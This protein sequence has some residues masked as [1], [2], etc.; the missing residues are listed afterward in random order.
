MTQIKVSI[1][2][3]IFNCEKYISKALE[4][5]LKQTEKNIEII[6]VNDGSTDKTM[7]ILSRFKD[8]RIKFI[9]KP[10]SGVAKTRL[11]GIE[12]ARGD[13]I[14]FI[15][16]DDT[17]EPDFL[18]KLLSKAEKENF[19]IVVCGYKRYYDIE[20]NKYSIEMTNRK[21]IH[22]INKK[23]DEVITINSA[24]WNK[25]YKTSLVK[26]INSI[27]N[28][29]RIAEDS[30]L[31]LQILRNAR[32]IGFVN[33]ALYNYYIRLEGLSSIVYKNDILTMEKAL[34][35]V[36]KQF[37]NSDKNIVLNDLAFLHL[38][39]FFTFKVSNCKN[40]N[41]DEYRKSITQFLDINFKEWQKFEYSK[42]FTNKNYC[43]IAF[44]KFIYRS[45]IYTILLR[46]YKNLNHRKGQITW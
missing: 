28:Y 4:S 2:I 6:C 37:S 3:P 18:S 45:K 17:I 35:E 11:Q 36:K 19:D 33:E 25:L 34:L 5:V 12:I 1:I 23:L 16:A 32:S 9:N 24:L 46:I 38:G 22:N 31:F 21:D 26:K 13:Y 42:I 29:P 10:N 7:E 8:D 43:K 20:K 14:C 15:D 41:L 44:L 30:I 27:D 39:V 40:E